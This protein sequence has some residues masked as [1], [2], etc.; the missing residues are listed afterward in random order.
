M[1]K[2]PHNETCQGREANES[3]MKA[4]RERGRER[5]GRRKESKRDRERREGTNRAGTE[6]AASGA[7]ALDGQLWRD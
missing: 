6:T 5:L 2:R 1:R 7:V 3:G 4:T